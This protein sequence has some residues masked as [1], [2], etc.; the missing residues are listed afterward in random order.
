MYGV[1]RPRR[2]AAKEAWIGA[3]HDERSLVSQRLIWPC[4]VVEPEEALDL[5]S[6]PSLV[7]R[8]CWQGGS[9]ERVGTLSAAGGEDL[10]LTHFVRHDTS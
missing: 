9:R 10:Q 8:L 4:L 5:F 7:C 3:V 6:G 1:R 2:S